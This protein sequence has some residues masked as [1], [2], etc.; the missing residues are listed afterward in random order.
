[1][2]ITARNRRHA[3]CAVL[4]VLLLNAF[5]LT[6]FGQSGSGPQMDQNVV[7]GGGGTSSSGPFKIE[8]TVGQS[9]TNI[10]TGGS[11][12]LQSGFWPAIAPVTSA[13]SAGNVNGTYGGA[14]TLTATL[15]TG[16]SNLSNKL[17]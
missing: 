1:M 9:V 8:G 16:G 13:L 11:F 17:I 5:A 6:L 3:F 15:N 12:S 14:V 7:A 10:S 4:L 2:K